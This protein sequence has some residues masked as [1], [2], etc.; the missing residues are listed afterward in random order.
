MKVALFAF[1]GSLPCFSHA[2][3][4]V[5]DMNERGD[6]AILILEGASV[7]LLPDL[8]DPSKPFAALFKKVVDNKYLDCVCKGCAAKMGTLEV[9]QK[10]SLPINGDMSGH[11]PM[12]DYLDKGYTIITV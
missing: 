7:A 1:T 5:L 11:P 2:L 9:A 8:L 6:T 3:L 10:A 4:N 12:K